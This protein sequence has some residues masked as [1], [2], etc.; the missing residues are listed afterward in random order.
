MKPSTLLGVA[1]VLLT[2]PASVATAGDAA[3]GQGLYESRCGA[4]HSVDA[5]RVGPAHQGVFGRKAGS[6]ADYLYSAALAASEILW[7]ETTLDAWLADPEGLIPGQKMGYSVAGAQE[8][9]DLIAYLR[10]L[11]E[12]P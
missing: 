9:A 6:A 2:A 1:W 10:S 7:T 11:S 8:R 4:C 12:P 3:R 5:H